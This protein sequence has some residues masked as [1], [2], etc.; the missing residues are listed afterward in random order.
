AEAYALRRRL[1]DDLGAAE[2]IPELVAVRHL[3][4]A[5]IDERGGL[6]REALTLLGSAGTGA[7]D[8]TRARIL[9]GLSAAYMLDRYL[10]DAIRYGEQSRALAADRATR[11]NTDITL[12]AVLVFAGPT[13][14]GW[15]LMADAT[16]QAC[17]A[18]LEAE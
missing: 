16:A 1:G 7:A 15:R 9:A 17:E 13:D 6:L 18:N 10:D 2:L 4:G 14:Q 12:G 11:L 3:L 8:G 5:G